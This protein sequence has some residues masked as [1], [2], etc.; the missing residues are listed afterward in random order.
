MTKLE[1]EA[2]AAALDARMRKLYAQCEQLG[3]GRRDVELVRRE[4]AALCR[5]LAEWN[6]GRPRLTLLQ[7]G[8]S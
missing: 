5:M 4:H 1:A 8:K 6:G 2:K 3:I 7:G